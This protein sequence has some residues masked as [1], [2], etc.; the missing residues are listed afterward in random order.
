MGTNVKAFIQC[1]KDMEDSEFIHLLTDRKVK[2][3]ARKLKR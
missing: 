3:V 1:M 2:H